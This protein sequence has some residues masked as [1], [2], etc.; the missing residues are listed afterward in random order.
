M[1]NRNVDKGREAENAVAAVLRQHGMAGA[2]RRAKRGGIVYLPCECVG[3]DE[4]PGC[5]HSNGRP[6][7]ADAGDLTGI[8][9][10]V[11][12][13]KWS[14]YK[15]LAEDMRRTDE[16]RRV[17]GADVG[18]LVRKRRGYGAA[19]AGE[20]DAYLPHRQMATLVGAGEFGQPANLSGIWHTD[21]RT[22]AQLLAAAGYGSLAVPA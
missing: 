18:L 7:P 2:E 21:L 15:P 9:G 6:V 20:W 22:A 14:G 12:Q 11:V 13:V 16:Q 4:A 10:V 19:R 8:P 17:A 5:D 3:M 1:A